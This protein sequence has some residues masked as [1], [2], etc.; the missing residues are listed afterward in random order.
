MTSFLS[1]GQDLRKLFSDASHRAACEGQPMIDGSR[2][3]D[4]ARSALK[5]SR[6]LCRPVGKPSCS[7]VLDDGVKKCLDEAIT[8]A[9]GRPLSVGAFIL[10]L[11]RDGKVDRKALKEAK[12]SE[13]RLIRRLAAEEEERRASEPRRDRSD[14]ILACHGRDLTA[15]AR[16][17]QLAAPFGRDKE[18]DEVIRTLCLRNKSNPLLLGEAGVGKT[19]V[20]EGLACR[21]ASGQVPETLAGARVIS[22]SA[23]ALTSA[24]AR[25]EGE[26]FVRRL[27]KEVLRGLEDGRM[28]ILFID[29][30]H[31]LRSGL[32]GGIMDWLKT[33]LARPGFR[34][35]GATTTAE[36]RRFLAT[37]KA[38]DRRF[39]PVHVDEF[40]PQA[41]LDVVAKASKAYGEHHGVNFDEETLRAAVDL[42]V[43]HLPDLR[44]PDK[45]LTLL[46]MAAAD[47]VIAGKPVT[48]ET[49]R[50]AT[51]RM[52]HLP[53]SSVTGTFVEASRDLKGRLQGRVKG[54][55]D[56]IDKICTHIR[57][58]AVRHQG[59]KKGPLGK[60]LFA[61]PTGV[62]KTELAKALAETFFGSED[63]IIRLDMSEYVHHTSVTRLIGSDPGFVD[64]GRG[65]FLTEAI[66]R[67]PF[68]LVLVDEVE[69]AA[70]EVVKLFLQILD[71]GH[72]T[73]SRGEKAD[74]RNAMI[75]MT[76]NA[77]SHDV[78]PALGFFD[79]GER[80]QPIVEARTSALQQ[81]FPRELLGRFQK[82]VFFFKALTEEVVRQI[83]R[84]Q[85][86]EEAEGQA[87]AGRTLIFDDAVIGL[88]ARRA[89]GSP[90][91]GRAVTAALESEVFPAMVSA[92]I[93]GD[94]KEIRLTVADDDPDRV[95]AARE[96]E[97]P[98]DR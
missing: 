16:S 20:A 44:L 69:K 70:P 10:E 83:A 63:R 7:P 75:V 52:A 82:G 37:D 42:S 77:G 92:V 66:R 3:F 15:L 12:T 31:S 53:L 91:G 18:C 41:A 5:L 96:G 33:A 48:V 2:L 57:S 62:G 88:V 28:T 14:S 49:M 80:E 59:H 61:G 50:Q 36:Y 79:E 93:D 58:L 4:E 8:K 11:L 78:K 19:A 68:S 84:K 64:S 34:L 40:S 76:T 46:D 6:P 73:D 56:V 71:E 65:G 86:E 45:A 55:D 97:R 24:A 38:I 51:A 67:N 72:L 81:E 85:L 29:E 32:G 21:V 27:E 26:E 98:D 47:A 13:S 23:S 1:C 90:Y 35:M 30:I 43:R 87:K 94:M 95:V 25:L 89:S 9:Q 39:Q 74:F 22:L 17:G 54:Q 60:F